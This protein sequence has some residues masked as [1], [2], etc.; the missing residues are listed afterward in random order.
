MLLAAPNIFLVDDDTNDGCCGTLCGII[1][2]YP[3]CCKCEGS[4]VCCAIDN[5]SCAFCDRTE[6]QKTTLLVEKDSSNDGCC[7]TACDHDPDYPVC[8]S[9]KGPFACCGKDKESCKTCPF[10]GVQ[11]AQADFL[12]IVVKSSK[13]FR[14]WKP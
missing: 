12:T 5:A 9:C 3:V 6:S 11:G 10:D 14:N 7:G 13:N 4:S 1:P 2:G 8:C